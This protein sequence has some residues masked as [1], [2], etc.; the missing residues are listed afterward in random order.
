MV[1]KYGEKAA[2]RLVNFDY[3]NVDMLGKFLDTHADKDNGH[4]DPQITWLKNGTVN[5]I[6]I[7]K[8]SSSSSSFLLSL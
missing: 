3:I 2:E 4:F 6:I 7:K 8:S 1:N 5:N